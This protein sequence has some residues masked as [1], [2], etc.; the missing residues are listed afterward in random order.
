M[1]N[2]PALMKAALPSKKTVVYGVLN[3]DLDQPLRCYRLDLRREQGLRRC[4]PPS[5]HYMN[6]AWR[7]AP[8]NHGYRL[9]QRLRQVHI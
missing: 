8:E 4:S 1:A 9:V 6:H 2:D 5:S 3:R 7:R